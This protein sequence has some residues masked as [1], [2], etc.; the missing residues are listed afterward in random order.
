MEVNPLKTLSET[1]FIKTQVYFKKLNM[2]L[3]N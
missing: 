3:P 1:N 2:K